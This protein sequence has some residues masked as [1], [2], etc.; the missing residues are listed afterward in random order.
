MLE[1]LRKTTRK[2]PVST[3]CVQTNLC[4]LTKGRDQMKKGAS[5]PAVEVF[6]MRLKISTHVTMC[7]RT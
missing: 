3:V 4:G 5:G 7:F 1:G 2:M 6:D